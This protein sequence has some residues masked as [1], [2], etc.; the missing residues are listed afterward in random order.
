MKKYPI[1]ILS[2]L[3]FAWGISIQFPAKAENAVTV[4]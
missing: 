2:L 1:L 4:E 3:S